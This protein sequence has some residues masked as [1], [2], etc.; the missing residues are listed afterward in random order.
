MKTTN[1]KIINPYSLE[2]GDI[3]LTRSKHTLPS[4]IIRLFTLSKYSHAAIYVGRGVIVEAVFS[5][6]RTQNIHRWSEGL[7]NNCAVLR[8]PNKIAAKRAAQICETY[9]GAMYSISDA[10]LSGLSAYFFITFPIRI[11]NTKMF[12]SRMVAEAFSN[13]GIIISDKH[14]QLVRPK[15]IYNSMYLAKVEV[16]FIPTTSHE[17][18]DH[19]V[20][21]QEAT[22]VLIRD[23]IK[24]MKSFKIKY[25]DLITIAGLLTIAEDFKDLSDFDLKLSNVLI[26]SE[27]YSL[28]KEEQ[29]SNPQ[30]WDPNVVLRISQ[31]DI[32]KCY[33]KIASTLPFH[34]RKVHQFQQEIK[35]LEDDCIY[36]GHTFRA[37]LNLRKTLLNEHFEAL[38]KF[39]SAYFYLNKLIQE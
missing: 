21:F 6:V 1:I 24:L 18:T 11:K 37:M 15:D 14:Y 19:T 27:F 23:V 22:I 5:G 8:H 13:S 4:F 12:C 38:M 10:I 34:S 29:K 25:K 36:K 7:E 35:A 31:N 16:D 26:N 30:N 32:E 3:I 2:P 33:I 9:H 20:I 28:W 39:K 17:K